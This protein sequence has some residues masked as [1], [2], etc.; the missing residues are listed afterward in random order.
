M[1]DQRTLDEYRA[2]LSVVLKTAMQAEQDL[3]AL[4]KLAHQLGRVDEADRLERL[5]GLADGLETG[6][7]DVTYEVDGL[8]N[9]GHTTRLIVA[10]VAVPQ[11][12]LNGLHAPSPLNSRRCVYCYAHPLKAEPEAPK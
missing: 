11:T 4:V 8:F 2:K 7:R 1:A 6:V 5:S 10:D 9:P 3:V 12:C